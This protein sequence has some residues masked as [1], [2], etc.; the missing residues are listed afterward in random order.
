MCPSARCKEVDF[1]AANTEEKR[2]IQ[3]TE[4]IKEATTSER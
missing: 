4:S 2:H 1:I 3:V